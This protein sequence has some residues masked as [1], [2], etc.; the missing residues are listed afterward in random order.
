MTGFHPQYDNKC[1]MDF[2][3][4]TDRFTLVNM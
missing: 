4:I 1:S 2:Y 3:I